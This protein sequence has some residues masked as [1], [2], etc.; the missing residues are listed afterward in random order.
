VCPVSE[1]EVPPFESTNRFSEPARVNI[2]SNVDKLI[3]LSQSILAKHVALGTASP[4]S[5]LKIA[6][7][8]ANTATA[9]AENKKATQLR[10]DA[11]KATQ[12]RDNA[13]SNNTDPLGVQFNV[14]SARD[15]L[16]AL[17]KGNER[18]LGDWG[19]DVDTSARPSGSKPST[20]TT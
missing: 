9:D 10:R 3:L 19:F 5:G 16:M 4:L 8:T 1:S 20:P 6:E 2:P 15:I 14:K 18:Q 17:N 11:E 13:L 7:W 12:N